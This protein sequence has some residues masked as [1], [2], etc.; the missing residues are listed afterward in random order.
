MTNLKENQ[1]TL[2]YFLLFFIVVMQS[3]GVTVIV[4]ESE[5]EE[6]SSKYCLFYFNGIV[7]RRGVFYTKC[8]WYFVYCKFI[9]ILLVLKTF[10][11]SRF[12]RKWLID[13]LVEFTGMST[14]VGLFYPKILRTCVHCTFM[15]I[16]LF[17]EKFYFAQGPIENDLFI[18]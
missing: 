15:I 16:F 18:D 1:Q 2:M 17:L 5:L 8:R 14:S 10:S 3:R 12:N 7:T 4:G 13:W 9:V 6:L 11:Y